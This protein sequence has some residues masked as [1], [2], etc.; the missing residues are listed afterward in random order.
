M[1]HD[2]IE[3]DPNLVCT[4]NDLSTDEINDSIEIGCEDAAE[5]MYDHATFFRCGECKPNIEK[6]ISSDK[7]RNP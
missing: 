5:V 7:R 2:R 4:C 3:R 6:L 1:D